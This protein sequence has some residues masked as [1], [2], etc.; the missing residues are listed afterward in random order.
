[1]CQDNCMALK[2]RNGTVKKHNKNQKRGKNEN[3]TI[4]RAE[5]TRTS[6]GLNNSAN[7]LNSDCGARNSRLLGLKIGEETRAGRPRVVK[8]RRGSWKAKVLSQNGAQSVYIGTSPGETTARGEVTRS[9]RIAV[10]SG[11]DRVALRNEDGERRKRT[12]TK[13][14]IAA[15]GIRK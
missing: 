1:M 14:E 10:L 2:T 15:S 13:G 8:S 5:I 9:R 6:N 7:Y 12:R 11:H 4:A 3:K